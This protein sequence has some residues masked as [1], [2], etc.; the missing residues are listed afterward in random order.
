MCYMKSFLIFIEISINR[1][2]QFLHQPTNEH[3][4]TVKRVLMYPNRKA[5]YMVCL[6]KSDVLGLVGL[7]NSDWACCSIEKRSTMEYGIY[8]GDSLVSWSARKLKTVVKS[9]IEIEYRALALSSTKVLFIFGKI[10][11][12]CYGCFH[13]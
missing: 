4:K 12:R 7:S 11:L 1:L 10:S 6:Q 13:S 8:F 2:Y 3:M 5:M 9:S